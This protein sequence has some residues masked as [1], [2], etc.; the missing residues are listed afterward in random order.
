MKVPK[1]SRVEGLRHRAHPDRS[2]LECLSGVG[3]IHAGP[4]RL[5]VGDVFGILSTAEIAAPVATQFQSAGATRGLIA[6]SRDDGAGH[7]SFARHGSIAQPET[8]TTPS[9]NARPGAVSRCMA[10]NVL[11][12]QPVDRDRR[13]LFTPHRSKRL[14]VADPVQVGAPSAPCVTS[15]AG[16][17]TVSVFMVGSRGRREV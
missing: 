1:S 12:A 2:G 13:T 15:T 14:A 16:M 4:E 11:D 3:R 17:M 7:G 10:P 8:A 9:T 6:M 5:P